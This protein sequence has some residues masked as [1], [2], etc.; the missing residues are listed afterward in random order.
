MRS[1]IALAL[2]VVL[3]ASCAKP[4]ELANR[5]CLPTASWGG[6]A[7][8]CTTGGPASSSPPSSSSEESSEREPPPA[9]EDTGGEIEMAGDPPPEDTPKETDRGKGKKDKDK[10]AD[11]VQISDA[12]G[13]GEGEGE[14]ETEKAGDRRVSIDGDEIRLEKKLIFKKDSEDLSTKSR[15]LLDELVAF[16][17]DHEEIKKIEI[18]GYTDNKGD[19]D[20]LKKLSSARARTVRDYLVDHG[21]K[22]KRVTSKGYGSADPIASNRTRSGRL[23]NRRIEIRILSKKKR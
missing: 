9:P 23:K 18:A 3:G 22:A 1:R 12:E 5:T 4:S 13:E 21:I 10:G 14:P 6:P 15:P 19:K 17:A 11:S 7:Y 16:L 20:E 8:S 2:A